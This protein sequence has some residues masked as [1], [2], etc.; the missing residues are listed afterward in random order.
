MKAII[1]GTTGQKEID[2]STP[3]GIH[4]SLQDNQTLGAWYV[5]PPSI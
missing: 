1:T 4:L 3:I 5:D 2:F